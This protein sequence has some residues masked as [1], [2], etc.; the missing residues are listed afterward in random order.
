MAAALPRILDPD[1]AATDF[2]FDDRIIIVEL[3]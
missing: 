3:E 1:Q 2:Y